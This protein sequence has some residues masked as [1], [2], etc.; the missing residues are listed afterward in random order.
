MTTVVVGTGYTGSRILYR[1][2]ADE[3]SGLTRSLPAEAPGRE[4]HLLDLDD[5][6]GP[7]EMP[8]SARLVYTVPPA[9]DADHDRRLEVFLAAL[10][11]APARIV[12]LSTTGVY[13]DH[14]GGTVTEDTPVSPESTRAARRV[15]A[16]DA[17]RRFGEASGTDITILRVP[18]IYG[19]DRL[20]IERVRD[21]EPVINESQADPGNRIH[22]DDLVTACLA[23]SDPAAPPGNYN[24][25][26]GDTRSSTWFAFE[27]ARQLGWPTP[28]TI[29]REEAEAT[30]SPM[31][32]SFLRESR[33]V[34]TTRM[35]EVL[36]VKLRYPDAADGI[37]ASLV[38]MGA[39]CRDG[40]SYDTV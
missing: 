27:V 9:T 6:V 5:D 34:D 31:R 22:V 7:I 19:P 2:P 13:G 11:A 8:E 16:E 12:Y 23:A 36:G 3:V 30:W 4:V 28:P 25:G 20:M 17:L 29:S 1:L 35:R 21:Q 15:A 33:I 32:L 39:R 40:E 24:L 14:A 38:E 37:R 18:G 10:S 26:D